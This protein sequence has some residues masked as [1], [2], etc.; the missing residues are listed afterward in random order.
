LAQS[1]HG[2]AAFLEFHTED[3]FHPRRADHLLLFSLRNDDAVPTVLSSVRDVRLPSGARRVLGERR[4][5]I[6]PDPEHV[7]QLS[8]VAPDHP[9]LSRIQA[10]ID[11]P[12]SACVMCSEADGTTIRRDRPFMR[13]LD[14]AAGAAL[15][16]LMAALVQV[17][18]DVVVQ[19]G[20]LLVIDNHVAVHGR[21]PFR[22]RYDGTDRWL[23][24]LL[25]S[26][27]LRH[28][29]PVPLSGS[30]RVLV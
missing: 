1:G 20:S 5:A 16:T 4:F 9:A 11:A 29:D 17:Q 30:G 21:R 19:P 15:E 18:Q 2:S 27:D 8:R 26:R 13:P 12:Q 7:R 24:K 6:L 14:S 23:K 10:M 3:A 28:G 22:A 25:V